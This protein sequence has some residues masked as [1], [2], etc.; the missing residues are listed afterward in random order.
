MKTV[1]RTTISYYDDDNRLDERHTNELIICNEDFVRA[2]KF[3]YYLRDVFS[4]E[5]GE[6][7]TKEWFDNDEDIDIG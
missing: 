4:N 5:F 3:Y 1:I 7:Q 2:E 6:L